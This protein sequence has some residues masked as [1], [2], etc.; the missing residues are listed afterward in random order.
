MIKSTNLLY[1]HFSVLINFC[2]CYHLL[3]NKIFFYQLPF[4]NFF[5]YRLLFNNLFY[6]WLLF[7]NYFYYHLLFNKLLPSLSQFSTQDA[8]QYHVHMFIGRQ[9]IRF[10]YQ[11]LE[12]IGQ[13]VTDAA[14]FVLTLQSQ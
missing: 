6:Y 12:A 2:F 7:N 10:Y 3:F 4:N 14:F 5:Y 13:A 9:S 1:I 8:K 11:N